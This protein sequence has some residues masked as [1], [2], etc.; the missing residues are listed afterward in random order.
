MV[1]VPQDFPPPKPIIVMSRFPL[2]DPSE[3][4]GKPGISESNL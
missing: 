1:F 2:A 3:I 4:V